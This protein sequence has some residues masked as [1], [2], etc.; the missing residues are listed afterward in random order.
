[1][2]RHRKEA[3][4]PT[5]K[6]A[7]WRLKYRKE[8]GDVPV[9]DKLPEG[10]DQERY[11]AFR[12]HDVFCTMVKAFIKNESIDIQ[13]IIYTY[14][15]LGFKRPFPKEGGSLLQLCTMIRLKLLKRG[16]ERNDIDEDPEE[17][18]KKRFP[19][20]IPHKFFEYQIHSQPKEDVMAKKRDDDD[21]KDRKKKRSRDDDDD[22][23]D[24]KKKDKKR[25][26]R[27]DDD[28]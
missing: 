13:G 3:I 24:R 7:V 19:R 25:R 21:R 16:F 11:D 18:I 27:D 23:K 15:N 22:R 26:H 1:M 14:W 10:F 12:D 6:L 2:L 4:D 5:D 8:H 28:D 17:Y 9:R 20:L